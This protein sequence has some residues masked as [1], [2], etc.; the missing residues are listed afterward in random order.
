[1]CL[2]MSS[3]LI[4]LAGDVNINYP[5]M[6]SANLVVGIVMLVDALLLKRRSYEQSLDNR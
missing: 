4:F 3:L 5:E 2:G 6:M 1:M